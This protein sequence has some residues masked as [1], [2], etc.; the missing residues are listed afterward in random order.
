MIELR[1]NT[2]YAKRDPCDKTSKNAM[3][4]YELITLKPVF[5]LLM[6]KYQKMSPKPRDCGL[7]SFHL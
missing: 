2:A 6:T 5:H 1:H 3:E 4:F 7:F